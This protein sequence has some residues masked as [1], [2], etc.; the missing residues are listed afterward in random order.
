MRE[1]IGGGWLFGIVIV[2]IFMF[3]GFLAYSVSYTKAFNVKNEI[4]NYIEQSQGYTKSLKNVKNIRDE[5]K[6]LSTTE[7]KTYNLVIKSGYDW[8]TNSESKCPSGKKLNEF[9]VC[10]EKFCP[11]SKNAV[12]QKGKNIHRISD[13]H[14]KVTTFMTFEIPFFKIR[15]TIPLTGETSKIKSDYSNYQCVDEI[16]N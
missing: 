6:L 9:G 11:T 3:S 15:F 4:V 5:S 14:Y 16:T 2:F 10:I 7:G 13:V 1:S 8:E 12:D